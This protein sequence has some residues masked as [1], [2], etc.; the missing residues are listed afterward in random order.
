MLRFHPHHD[1]A[2][3]ERNNDGW[4]VS[5]VTVEQGQ[6]VAG[7]QPQDTCGVLAG[8]RRQ[9][10]LG[11]NRKQLVDMDTDISHEARLA[12]QKPSLAELYP[13]DDIHYSEES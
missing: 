7:N 2:F 4:I 5:A 10:Q 1:F 8:L 12:G 9:R 3:A 13:P 11:A 6:R